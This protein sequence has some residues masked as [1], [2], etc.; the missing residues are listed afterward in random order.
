MSLDI[1]NALELMATLPTDA[2]EAEFRG[3]GGS[4]KRAFAIF[5]RS[6][7]EHLLLASEDGINT[8][9]E[10][11]EKLGVWLKQRSIQLDAFEHHTE[12]YLKYVITRHPGYMDMMPLLAKRCQFFFSRLTS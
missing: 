3:I 12:K 1:K 7:S 4:E 9:Q 5:F 2:E 11:L 10:S 6:A 8:V